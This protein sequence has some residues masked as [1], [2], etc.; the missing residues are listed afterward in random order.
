MKN[1]EIASAEVDPD[2]QIWL[3][4]DFFNNSYVVAGHGAATHKIANYWL[5]AQQIMS[6][7]V[8]WLV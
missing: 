1:V 4:K 7:L 5:F 2:H 8:T 6:Q 3:D